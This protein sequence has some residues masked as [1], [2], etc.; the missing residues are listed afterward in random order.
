MLLVLFQKLGGGLTV[1]DMEFKG[2]L[3]KINT[4]S[5]AKIRGESKKKWNFQWN[6]EFLGG[7]GFWSWNFQ[8]CKGLSYV[9]N[10][11]LQNF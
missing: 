7:L 10:T 2:E 3:R 5:N 8:G 11:I 6:V 1:E 9:S 4:W